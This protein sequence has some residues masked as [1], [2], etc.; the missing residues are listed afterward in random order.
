MCMM[1]TYLWRMTLDI[2]MINLHYSKYFNKIS[3]L[4]FTHFFTS[5]NSSFTAIVTIWKE[6]KLP[7]ELKQIL[8]T[9]HQDLVLIQKPTLDHWTYAPYGRNKL[10]GHDSSDCKNLLI[11]IQDQPRSYTNLA[12]SEKGLQ[13][14]YLGMMRKLVKT[15]ELKILANF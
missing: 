10:W 5:G 2:G 7:L 4:V 12:P 3:P 15:E 6:S 11:K 13:F 1:K 9:A 14:L 8:L